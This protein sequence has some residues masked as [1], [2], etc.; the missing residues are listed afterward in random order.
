MADFIDSEIQSY[1]AIKSPEELSKLKRKKKMLTL[2]RS[3][4]NNT[5]Q[6][7]EEKAGPVNKRTAG[8]KYGSAVGK[9][10]WIL[11]VKVTLTPFKELVAQRPISYGCLDTAMDAVGTVG[12]LIPWLSPLSDLDDSYD[13]NY[14]RETEDDTAKRIVRDI[15]ATVIPTLTIGG[16]VAGGIK[17]TA[18]SKVM[19]S[20]RTHLLG[21]ISAEAGVGTAVTAISD[22]SEEQENLA[23]LFSEFTGVDIPWRHI[24]GD[25]PYMTFAKNMIEDAF[26]NVGG[27]AMEALVASRSITKNIPKNEEA[28]QYL[29]E[30][31]SPLA[32]AR[33]EL[34][35]PVAAAVKV[36]DDARF[37][38]INRE[39]ILRLGQNADNPNPY[40]DAFIHE[41]HFPSERSVKNYN[42]NIVDFKTDVARMAYNID[43]DEVAGR[44][45]PA[46]TPGMMKLVGGGDEGRE[47]ALKQ[48][49][50]TL[51]VINVDTQIGDNLITEEKN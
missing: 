12:E 41:P 2:L 5:E 48:F 50:Q 3:Q 1:D 17:A 51:D 21:R 32:A 24:D 9:V 28:A 18:A 13:A 23:T 42:A 29:G 33:E 16:A 49:G 7:L 6:Q 31:I 35:D 4:S 40:Y 14:G 15:A 25:S 37:A 20:S 47:A 43:A 10:P 36:N 19:L 39:T 11:P 22:Q 27:A 38:E 30:K 44:A 46:V 26:F 8:D 45:R 34:G